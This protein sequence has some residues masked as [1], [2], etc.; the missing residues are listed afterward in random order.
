MTAENTA[1]EPMAPLFEV[2]GGCF[3]YGDGDVL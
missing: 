1:A 2:R 3:S